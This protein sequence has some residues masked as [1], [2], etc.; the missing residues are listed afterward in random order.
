MLGSGG[1]ALTDTL[2]KGIS[3][4]LSADDII[5][6]IAEIVVAFTTIWS[7]ISHTKKSKNE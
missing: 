7:L 1:I 3:G 4:Q 5:K 6:I 2:S